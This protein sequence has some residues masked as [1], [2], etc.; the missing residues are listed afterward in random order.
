MKPVPLAMTAAAP[1]Q[2]A[3]G[4]PSCVNHDWPR[5][6]ARKIVVVSKERKN[7]F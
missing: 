6:V 3:S 1:P 5:S 2:R 4:R 7:E